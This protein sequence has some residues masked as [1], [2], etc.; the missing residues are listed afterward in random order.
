MANMEQ[1]RGQ[2]NRLGLHFDWDR[3]VIT[4]NSDYYRWTQDLF[5]RLYKANLAYQDDAEVNWDPVDKTVL[6]NE[7][8]GC[9]H[10]S[11][12]V[13]IIVVEILLG[14]ERWK[15]VAF[16]SHCGEE[17]VSAVVHSHNGLR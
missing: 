6:A 10:S 1:M 15:I 7:Q 14:F 11:Q 9:C 8:V 13:V 16:R 5:L 2:L 3:E 12:G 17:E 4:C